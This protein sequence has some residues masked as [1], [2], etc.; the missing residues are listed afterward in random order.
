MER[1]MTKV[2]AEKKTCPGTKV[3]KK[4]T[5]TYQ[6]IQIHRLAKTYRKKLRYIPASR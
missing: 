6:G 5:E 1:F 3:N 2:T 4:H